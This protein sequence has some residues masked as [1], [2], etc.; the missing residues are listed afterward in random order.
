MDPDGTVSLASP[1]GEMQLRRRTINEARMSDS[2]GRGALDR[3]DLLRVG[4]T[5]GASGLAWCGV[6]PGDGTDETETKA[7]STAPTADREAMPNSDG[8]TITFDGGGA[9]A[10]ADAL[11]HLE[12]NPGS[13]LEIEPGTYHLNGLDVDTEYRAAHFVPTGLRDVTTNRRRWSTSRSR[14]EY[15]VVRTC[16]LDSAALWNRPLFCS[17][18]TV[19]GF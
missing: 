8:D 5:V 10:F 19:G 6:L 11:T 7:H 1:Q 15:R 17:G 2:G 12:H 18:F 13:T 9:S 14:F 4:A 16:S 3:R